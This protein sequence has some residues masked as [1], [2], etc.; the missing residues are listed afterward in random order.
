MAVAY[1][2]SAYAALGLMA[3]WPLAAGFII[4]WVFR[5]IGLEPGSRDRPRS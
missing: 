2:T 1:G 3:W 5:L 4:A